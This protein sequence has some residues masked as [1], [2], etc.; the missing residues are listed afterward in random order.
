MYQR[1]TQLELEES[2]AQLGLEKLLNDAEEAERDGRASGTFYA[3][4]L[5]NRFVG[6]MSVLI[7]DDLKSGDARRAHVS[8]V[9]HFDP[10]LIA[11]IAVSN[12]LNYAMAGGSLNDS[13][14]GMPVS[15]MRQQIG[16]ALYNEHFLQAFEIH[17]K[18]LFHTLTD[19]LNRRR[20]QSARH[21]ST[22]MKMSAKKANVPF[23]EWSSTNIAQV[24]DWLV[25]LLV[26]CGMITV[27]VVRVNA[28]KTRKVLDITDEV[29]E[30]IIDRKKVVSYFRPRRTPFVEKPLPWSGLVGGGYH[31]RRMQNTFP[32]CIKASP[33]QLERIRAADISR[34]TDCINALQEVGWSINQ[35]VLAV[36]KDLYRPFDTNINNMKPDPLD[37]H[38]RDEATWTLEEQAQ[39]KEWKRSMAKWYTA[40]KLAKYSSARSASTIM[41]AEEFSQ[42]SEFYFMYFADWRG[43]YYPVTS[44]ISPQGPDEQKGL[45]QFSEGMPLNTEDAVRWFLIHGTSKYGYDKT[46]IQSRIDWVKEHHDV[47][48]ACAAD[49][50]GN[51]H[52]WKAADKPYQFLAWCFEYS[53]WM[54]LGPR[55]LSYL[56]VSM[57]GSCNGLQNY[58]ALGRDPIGGAATNLLPGPKPSDIYQMVADVTLKLIAN[59]PSEYAALWRAHGINRKVVKRCVM[60][61]PYG[62]KKFSFTRFIQYDYLAEYKPDG[63]P[64]EKWKDMASFLGEYVWK[65]I[66]MV[67]VQAIKMMAYF[68]KCSRAITAQK[69]VE[70]IHW[71]AM[72]G[73][74]ITQAYYKVEFVQCRSRVTGTTKLKVMQETDRIDKN[75]HCDGISPNIIHSCDG[76]HL[77]FTVNRAKREGMRHFAMIHDDY[78]THAANA[79]HLSRLIREEF[80]AMYSENVFERL[81]DELEAQVK[82]E[83]KRAELTRSRP[84]LGDLDLTQVLESKFFFI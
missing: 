14:D 6:R 61:L 15:A 66:G 46:D 19:D 49:P 3:K 52:L 21:Y 24:G 43:R 84:E 78:G 80:V 4:E 56:P 70:Y 57:D 41:M 55:F 22:V 2:C 32:R 33:T 59:D 26:K 62:A 83:E 76:S 25:D 7:E 67:V 13:H 53:D 11:F 74:P 68:Q 77:T 5:L 51:R 58:S 63:I 45:L 44:C 10:R 31:S 50:V 79:E 69:G 75:A 28:T 16:T 8:L 47:I 82:D 17:N 60:T 42:Y 29:L 20:S 73:L 64:P 35:R 39:H 9:K 23:Y 65:A 34:V 71:T 38:S 36:Q 27:E 72:S 40:Q 1:L 48:M 18:E 12:C 54:L 37:C 30:I 81:A